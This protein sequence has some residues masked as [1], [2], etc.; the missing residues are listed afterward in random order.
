[1]REPENCKVSYVGY[2]SPRSTE[3]VEFEILG[4]ENLILKAKEKI[5]KLKQTAYL[6]KKAEEKELSSLQELFVEEK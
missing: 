5:S 3:E 1:M 2:E 4:L 6:V